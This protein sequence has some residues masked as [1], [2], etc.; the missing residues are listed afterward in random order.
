MDLH[1]LANTAVD[2]V[3]NPANISWVLAGL[4]SIEQWLGASSSTKVKSISHLLIKVYKAIKTVE[5][6]EQEQVKTNT[7]TEVPKA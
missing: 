1:I 2:W 4:L 6:F 3:T 5:V 7:T